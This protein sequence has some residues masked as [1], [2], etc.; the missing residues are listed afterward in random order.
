MDVFCRHPNY[1]NDTNIPVKIAAGQSR[2]FKDQ[3]AGTAVKAT[4]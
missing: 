4:V 2:H 3:A 1:F